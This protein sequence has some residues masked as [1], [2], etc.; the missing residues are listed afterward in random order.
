MKAEDATNRS[1]LR[2][3]WQ[4]V[5]RWQGGRQRG[6]YQKLL[7]LIA[8]W[9]LPFDVYLLRFPE[10]SE[11]AP[12]R[13]PVAQG[14]HFRLNLILKSARRG[15]DFIC[16]EPIY[17]SKRI[18]LFRPDACEHRVTRVEQGTRYLLSIGWVRHS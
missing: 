5:G 11:I 16:A 12:H 3:W 2:H 6:G 15:G 7:I 14:Q 9:P 1:L 13:D 17:A 4:H 18:K 10:G 8:R